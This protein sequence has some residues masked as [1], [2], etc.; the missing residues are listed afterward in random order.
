LKK[1]DKLRQER[2]AGIV[3]V[4][5]G[6]KNDRRSTRFTVGFQLYLHFEAILSP[7]ST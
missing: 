4:N 2:L 5:L 6:M 3:A 7:V 1:R